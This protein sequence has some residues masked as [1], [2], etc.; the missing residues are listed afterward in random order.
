MSGAEQM[1]KRIEFNTLKMSGHGNLAA[2]G[3]NAGE[4]KLCADDASGLCGAG[5]WSRV[6]QALYV[7]AAM[8][9]TGFL[10]GGSAHSQ[11]PSR[12]P[13]PGQV[14]VPSQLEPSR[15]Q[16]NLRDGPEVMSEP[17]A[18]V[19]LT[20]DA[21]PP[22]DAGTATFVFNEMKIEG[23]TML[24]T[25]S[26]Y[27]LWPYSAGDTVSVEDVFRLA[28]AITQAYSQAG[29]A[30]SFA[31]VP[32]QSIESGVVRLRV[33]EG[34]VDRVE[35]VGEG[36]DKIAG[37]ATLRKAEQ[38]ASRILNSR[39]L[40]MV[41]LERYILLINDLPGLE[42]STVLK[43]S[44]E[45]NGAAVLAIEVRERKAYGVGVAYNNYMPKSLDRDVV[46]ASVDVNGVF[47]GSDQ[48]K[49]SGWRGLT[50][51]AYWS[52]SAEASI[53]VGNEGARVGVSGQYS[54]S[55]PTGS[56]LSALEY[57]GETTNASVWAQYPLIR[58]RTKNLILGTALSVTDSRSEILSAPLTRDRLR[59][60]EFSAAYDFA[61]ESRAVT[62]FRVGYQRGLD[63]FNATGNSR[64]DAE[65]EYNV[66][67][68]DIQRTQPLLQAMSGE[69]SAQ[70]G[71]RGQTLFDEGGLYSSVECSYG[72]RGFGRAY[73]SGILTGDECALGFGELRWNGRIGTLGTE[74]YGFGDAGYLWQNG[75][76]E[77]GE[78]RAR[79][80]ASAGLGARLQLTDRVSGLLETS[81]DV[82]TPTGV[83]SADD[84]R[85]SAG[86]R[87]RF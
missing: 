67:T 77:P 79:A 44:L 37:S 69:I 11:M 87:T 39:P 2:P 36:A 49:L 86:I 32:E 60:I 1:Q 12:V 23:A 73:D 4:G 85:I 56:F 82:G 40:R 28:N 34:Y 7:T 43:P 41:D 17:R 83:V 76:L 57:L 55:S 72:G 54:N 30:L 59:S 58:S 25:Q 35:F 68:L 24:P 38:I 65:L 62:Y 10:A 5:G 19:P 66:V 15:P 16:E 22:A 52:G 13:D 3:D 63:A 70:V 27:G 20:Q 9:A 42:V 26:L 18:M 47:A 31:V 64:A 14:D 50:S 74:I 51:D 78:R 29:Y 46:G 33:V 45:T 53:G 81:W 48:L 84:M 6:K 61:D 8:A 80:A 75:G 21:L 71:L